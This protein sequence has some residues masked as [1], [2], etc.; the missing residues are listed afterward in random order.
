[1]ALSKA[2][3][4]EGLSLR[5]NVDTAHCWLNEED[6]LEMLRALR[7][8]V[9]EFHFSNCVGDPANPL[10]DDRHLAFGEP[11]RMTHREMADILRALLLTCMAG[12]QHLS[13]A[14]VHSDY[15]F[16]LRE[17]GLANQFTPQR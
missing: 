4:N 6:P 15:E 5:I 1:M 16:L 13:Q 8:S 3:R 2:L 9:Q 17:Q 14:R 10:Y 7:P 12:P 11:G